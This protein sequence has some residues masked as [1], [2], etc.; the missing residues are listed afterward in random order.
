MTSII[1]GFLEFPQ[2]CSLGSAVKIWAKQ[3][4]IFETEVVTKSWTPKEKRGWAIALKEMKFYICKGKSK[5]RSD[6]YLPRPIHLI[7]YRP[8]NEIWCNCQQPTAEERYSAEL[9]TRRAAQY[10]HQDKSL[11]LAGSSY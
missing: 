5:Q 1:K 2:S 3:N 10:P 9:F 6:K 4:H 8:W 11:T 7:Y